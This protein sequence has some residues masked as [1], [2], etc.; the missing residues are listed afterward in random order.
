MPIKTIL[1][2]KGASLKDHI[3]REG[4]TVYQDDILKGNSP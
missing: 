1:C 2:L 4:G 3:V